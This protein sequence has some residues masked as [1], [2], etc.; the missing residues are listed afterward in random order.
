MVVCVYVCGLA[1][2]RAH[3]VFNSDVEINFLKK[4][5]LLKLLAFKNLCWKCRDNG[6]YW[7][8]EIR[9]PIR[10]LASAKGRRFDT[11]TAIISACDLYILESVLNHIGCWHSVFFTGSI[12]PC[13]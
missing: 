11:Y 4:E 10:E 13:T 1:H 6:A 12:D 2:T 9:K 7:I 8:K 5:W 3:R